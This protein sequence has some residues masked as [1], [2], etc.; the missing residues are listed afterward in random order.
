MIG[1]ICEHL[2][3][4]PLAIELAA[5]RL[6]T[7]SLAEL[8]RRLT[9]RFR[10]LRSPASR[11]ADERHHTLRATVAWSYQL[12]SA[13]EQTLFDRLS[14]FPARFDLDAAEIVCGTPPLDRPATFDLLA[15]LV[16]KSLVVLDPRSGRY[17]LLETLR[18]YGAERL[19][20]RGEVGELRARHLAHYV[21]VAEEARRWYEG[22]RN[23]DGRAVFAA[24]WDNLRAA[25][26][27]AEAAGEGRAA[28]A[29]VRAP[30]WFACLGAHDEHERWAATRAPSSTDSEVLACTAFWADL[31]RDAE[32]SLSHAMAERALAAAPAPDHPFALHARFVL[33]A[34][35]WY[36]GRPTEARAHDV[37]LKRVAA[38]AEPSLPVLF[39]RAFIHPLAAA[40][41]DAA[42]AVVDAARHAG[43]P[44][45]NETLEAMLA[46]HAGVAAYATGAVERARAEWHRSAAVAERCGCPNIEAAALAMLAVRGAVLERDP[47]NLLLDALQRLE[48]L[49]LRS[50]A[51]WAAAGVADWW[52][53]CGRIEEAA[54]VI[55]FLD[56]H[57]PGGYQSV[58]DLRDHA[59]RMVDAHAGADE[60]RRR[61]A[62]MSRDEILRYCVERLGVEA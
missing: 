9:D 58:A 12:L 18:Q 6:R 10:V 54:H 31:T 56:R 7:M 42:P 59:T 48:A 60:W 11:T 30:F 40:T 28:D 17:R 32:P 19:G 50:Y 36:G 44:L 22:D 1:R 53:R 51:L 4:M 41:P 47:E 49:H 3:G 37:E 38:G 62:A 52:V 55:G 21:A 57:D 14:V 8:E 61:G 25:L 39:F 2:D 24:E 5:G 29:L 34:C 35:A 46:F 43:A 15:S 27:W 20:A 23:A 26:D 13:D 45:R 16:D 33:T